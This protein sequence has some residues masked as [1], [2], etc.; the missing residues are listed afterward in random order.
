MEP[1]CM[2]PKLARALVSCPCGGAVFVIEPSRGRVHGTTHRS[3]VL[4][5]LYNAAKGSSRFFKGIIRLS[6]PECQAVQGRARVTT[7]PQPHKASKAL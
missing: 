3:Q 1:M 4:L 6:P 2:F 5:R 7:M